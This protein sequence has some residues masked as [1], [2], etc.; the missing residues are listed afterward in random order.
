MDFLLLFDEVAVGE[1]HPIKYPD[2]GAKRFW[3]TAPY[4]LT[5]ALNGMGDQID[6]PAA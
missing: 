3:F 1:V 5:S 2:G 4:F 6:A